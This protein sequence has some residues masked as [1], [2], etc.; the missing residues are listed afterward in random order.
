MTARNGASRRQILK[1]AGVTGA[2]LAAVVGP[3]VATRR[4]APP[5]KVA[6]TAAPPPSPAQAQEFLAGLGGKK[7]GA[8]AVQSIGA[9]DRGGIPV[10]MTNASGESFRVD[11]LRADP[12][13]SPGIGIASTVSVYLRNGGD[14]RTV[15]DEDRGL[16]AMALAKELARRSRKGEK[17]PAAL[18]TMSERAALDAVS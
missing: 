6:A 11:V 13:G 12:F 10:I 4:A 2:A 1:V 3:R 18:L 14:G 7:L 5:A 17:P 16:G 15:T 9:I 8:Y